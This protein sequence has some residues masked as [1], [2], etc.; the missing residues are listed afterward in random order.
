MN[1]TASNSKTDNQQTLKQACK[2]VELMTILNQSTSEQQ[3]YRAAAEFIPQLIE[4]DD[5]NI[6]LVKG[7]QPLEFITLTN[8][9]GE[10]LATDW[11]VLEKT[12]I[13]DVL[14]TGTIALYLA[15]PDSKL[16]T[17]QSILIVPLLAHDEIVGTLNLGRESAK[18]FSAAEESLLTQLA[19][20]LALQIQSQHQ[21]VQEITMRD[22]VDE[23]A[24]LASCMGEMTQHLSWASKESEL[25]EV[26]SEYI[27][28]LI[29]CQR[30]S[31]TILDNDRKKFTLYAV[32][33]VQANTL[34]N[35]RRGRVQDDSGFSRAI[36]ERA[37]ISHIPG[38]MLIDQGIGR[39]YILPLITGGDVIGTLNI[40]ISGDELSADEIEI[41][42]QISSI[43]AAK[44]Q[45]RRNAAQTEQALVETSRQS[46]LLTL[47]NQYSKAASQVLNHAALYSLTTHHVSEMFTVART[48]V[49]ILHDD[50]QYIQV[51]DLLGDVL[52]LPQGE[53]RPVSKNTVICS[54]ITTRKPV[55]VP[56]VAESE[57]DFS[58]MGAMD[59][60]SVISVPMLVGERAIGALNLASREAFAFDERDE[61]LL[62]Q[63]AAF[64][65]TTWEKL[66]LIDAAN[67]ARDAAEAANIAKSLFLANMSHEIRTPMNGVIG[68]TGLLLE[69]D[70]T[71]EQGDY[72]ETIR[73]SGELLL[74]VIND[75]L[76][77]SKIEAGKLEL[78]KL[79]FNVADCVKSTIDLMS[80]RA[81]EKGLK[82]TWTLGEKVPQYLVGDV[83]RLRQILLN[84]LSNAVKFTD[85]GTVGVSLRYQDGGEHKEQKDTLII[86]VQDSGIGLTKEQQEQLFTSFTQAD[87]SMSRRFGGTGLG[88]A[89]CKR[90]TNLMGGDIQVESSGL[91]GAGSTFICTIHAPASAMN[92]GRTALRQV[93][94]AQSRGQRISSGRHRMGPL[95]ENESTISSIN[96][97]RQARSAIT[98]LVAEDNTVNQKLILNMLQKLG[99]SADLVSN[100]VEVLEELKKQFYDIILM[101]IQ[102]PHMDG[103]EATKKIR[104]IEQKE[105]NQRASY[106]IA[107]TANA[108]SGD[109]EHCIA[110]GMDDYLSK[111]VR[112]NELKMA[113]QTARISISRQR[114]T[115]SY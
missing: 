44:I 57:Y 81:E 33:G 115:A 64:F 31:L 13:A 80:L 75:I 3:V 47:L 28:Q 45:S 63:I 105:S 15:D 86:E 83:T 53:I 111:P 67:D 92:E 52:E 9:T 12:S 96:S 27:P 25:Y 89:I 26:A 49:A 99:L 8:E 4:I 51:M 102:M 68:M 54:A 69:T 23:R 32:R 76:D 109:R 46:E 114:L 6:A 78:E 82:L 17:L 5:A 113:I 40:G 85:A 30:C 97:N 10:T 91:P 107:L 62:L 58:S 50:K 41:V 56:N 38:Q 93:Q 42:K 70:L 103:L 48:T 73:D 24:R 22:L 20:V 72:V 112:I 19:A 29:D 87:I 37:I 95:T 98:I 1:L 106:I 14:K 74:A 16:N 35:A 84:L 90:L 2:I 77:F 18:S 100:G 88:L 43:L 39:S 11:R 59:F 65:G 94:I 61:N 66:Q 36:R 55:N 110:V 104:K 7:E 79:D 101:D 60:Q 108:M 71:A 34:S 21:R